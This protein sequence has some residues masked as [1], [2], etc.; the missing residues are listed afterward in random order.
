MKKRL[1]FTLVMA[2]MMPFMMHAQSTPVFVTANQ[3]ACASYT[4]PINGQTYTES[5]VIT[6]TSNDTVYVLN[7]TINPV[8][9]TPIASNVSGVCSM[10]FND[11]MRYTSGTYTAT[12][13]TVAGNCD[14]LVSLN[15]TIANNVSRTH[16]VISCGPYTWKGTDYTTSGTIT[17]NFV[18]SIS[19]GNGYQR[20]DSNLTLILTLINPT[21]KENHDTIVACDRIRFRFHA[22]ENYNNFGSKGY[23]YED[24]VLSTNMYSEASPYYNYYHKRGNNAEQCYDTVS[25]KH[26]FVKKSTVTHEN[27]NACGSY[28]LDRSY[29]TYDTN[30]IWDVIQS[31]DS[32]NTTIY[33]TIGC[34]TNIVENVHHVNKVFTFSTKNEKFYV[35][36]NEVGCADSLYLDVITINAFP[37]MY[38]DGEIDLRPDNNG[39]TLTA[40]NQTTS[41]SDNDLKYNWY[42][43]GTASS[44]SNT[45]EYKI[46]GQIKD[47][48]DITLIA[49]HKTSHC[50][51][52]T[53]VT[54]MVNEGIANA[55]SEGLS[56]YPNPAVNNINIECSEEIESIAV[57]NVLGQRLINTYDKPANYSLSLSSLNNGNYT[58]RI[59]TKS[60]KVMVRNII[61]AR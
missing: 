36:A 7:L 42:K 47:N 8:Y 31:L 19:N 58:I 53:V 4:W 17:R 44:Q 29:T 22:G 50:A 43:T 1:F 23:F 11:T 52:T 54:I 3:S 35:G 10:E 26:L 18:D 25:Y 34:D 20:C 6:Y 37:D 21:L 41:I 56:M 51:D 49:E 2:L 60:G 5:Q 27:V 48:L 12:L 33:D 57:Y 16:E 9:T 45:N 28:T 38:I 15:L 32:T 13:K 59:E 24:T 40:I 55:E 46:E 30:Y 39:T 61:I 14:S